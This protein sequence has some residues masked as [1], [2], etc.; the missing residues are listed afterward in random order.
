ANPPGQAVYQ[1]GDMVQQAVIVDIRPDCV[2]FE[3]R[4]GQRE[5]LC[6]QPET[7]TTPQQQGAVPVPGGRSMAAAPVPP[8]VPRPNEPG[9]TGIVRVD[10]GTWRIGRDLIMENFANVGSLSSQAT[11]TPYFVQGQQQGFRLSQIRTGGILL[12]MGLEEGDVLQTGS[13]LTLC[14]PQKE[15][16]DDK[17]V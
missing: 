6:F 11:V 14:A 2:T 1:V 12:Q 3:K 10:P 16:P 5:T 15:L 8:P 4:S 7:G 9:N 13:G 17:P